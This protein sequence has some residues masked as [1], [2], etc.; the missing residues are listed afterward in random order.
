V[1]C[2]TAVRYISCDTGA[3]LQ[4]IYSADIVQHGPPEARPDTHTPGTR[5]ARDDSG[6]ALVCCTIDHTPVIIMV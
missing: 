1:S 6:V 5:S 3:M 4:A 2:Y